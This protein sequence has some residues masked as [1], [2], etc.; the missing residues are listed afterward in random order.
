MGGIFFAL[1]ALLRSTNGADT[2]ASTAVDTSISVYNI[3]AV[4]LGNSTNGTTLSA[5]AASDT[6]IRNLISH[7]FILLNYSKIVCVSLPYVYINDITITKFC[8]AF[9]QSLTKN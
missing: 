6:F 5:S 9:T 4:T 1:S 8:K 7:S 2:C 3:L